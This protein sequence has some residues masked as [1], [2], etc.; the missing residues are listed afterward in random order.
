[1]SII[2]FWSD[3]LERGGKIL[4]ST[5]ARCFSVKTTMAV[6]QHQAVTVTRFLSILTFILRRLWLWLRSVKYP[7]SASPE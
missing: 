1:M 5:K 6:G 7:E 2:S 4:D 3:C